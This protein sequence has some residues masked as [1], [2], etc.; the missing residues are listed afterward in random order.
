MQTISFETK[1]KYHQD[2]STKS[3]ERVDTIT[4][5][6][7]V[8]TFYWGGGKLSYIETKDNRIILHKFFDRFGHIKKDTRFDGEKD[9]ENIWYENGILEKRTEY[10]NGKRHGLEERF[11]EQ[12]RLRRKACYFNG[13][14]ESYKEYGKDNNLLRQYKYFF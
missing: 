8:E 7:I 14:I 9:I 1:I 5:I 11:D 10:V 4:G 12:G 2:G 13:A 6:S 3:I